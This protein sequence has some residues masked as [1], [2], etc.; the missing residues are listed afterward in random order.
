MKAFANHVTM[1]SWSMTMSPGLTTP[2]TNVSAQSSAFEGWIRPVAPLARIFAGG[3]GPG[4][5][6]EG[7]RGCSLL[8]EKWSGWNAQVC[9]QFGR[10]EADANRGLPSPQP[11][12]E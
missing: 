6:S 11:A 4:A 1:R 3:F 12:L 5:P 8:E 10:A 7:T 2:W 9:L